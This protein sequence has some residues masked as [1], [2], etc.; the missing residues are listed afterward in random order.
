MFNPY[1]SQIFNFG[2]Q[3]LNRYHQ[4]FP[5]ISILKRVGMVWVSFATFILNCYTIMESPQ[6]YITNV[7]ATIIAPL[8]FV[9]IASSLYFLDL[10]VPFK[11]FEKRLEICVNACIFSSKKI[12]IFHC[13]FQEFGCPLALMLQGWKFI[14]SCCLFFWCCRCSQDI[15]L[16]YYWLV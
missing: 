3:C 6:S 12:S 4:S 1:T 10:V 9:N 7:Q 15:L 5:W 8:S 13:L 16:I 14:Y 11:W 2:C